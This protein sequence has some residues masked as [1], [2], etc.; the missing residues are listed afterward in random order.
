[1]WDWKLDLNQGS[2]VRVQATS[3]SS[4]CIPLRKQPEVISSKFGTNV[5][6]GNSL[7]QRSE[8][9]VQPD[10]LIMC[11]PSGRDAQADSRHP[12]LPLFGPGVDEGEFRSAKVL[13]FQTVP[14]FFF[15]HDQ[16]A[17]KAVNSSKDDDIM[18]LI[19]ATGGNLTGCF[20]YPSSK[21]PSALNKRAIIEVFQSASTALSGFFLP[22]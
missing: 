11:Q 12:R 22:V 16:S 9:K 8:V 10:L 1:M 3:A 5:G 20:I 4:L 18:A 2:E 17:I 6:P 14:R 15:L 13:Q 21:D 7:S 19:S